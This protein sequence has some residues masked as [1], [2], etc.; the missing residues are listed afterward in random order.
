M[1]CLVS[2]NR[3]KNRSIEVEDIYWKE[4]RSMEVIFQRHLMDKEKKHIKKR[5]ETYKA[6]RKKKEIKGTRI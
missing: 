3:K 1:N 6:K 5:K 4:K 2:L